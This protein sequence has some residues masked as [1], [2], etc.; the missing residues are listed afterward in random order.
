MKKISAL[1]AL[2]MA[3]LVLAAPAHADN[4]DRGRINIAGYSEASLCREALAIVPFALP[5][6]APAVNDACYDRE[7][8]HDTQ[9]NAQASH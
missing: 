9:E 7:H 6:T 1:A 5:L 4:G 3:A 2:T 8:V